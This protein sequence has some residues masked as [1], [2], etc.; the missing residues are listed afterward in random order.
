ME[1]LQ[2][3]STFRRT[4]V[5][6]VALITKFRVLPDHRKLV[7]YLLYWI[8]FKVKHMQQEQFLVILNNFDVSVLKF[9]LFKMYITV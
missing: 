4:A 1:I 2:V 6:G 8:A 9:Q 7:Y 5:F 3:G